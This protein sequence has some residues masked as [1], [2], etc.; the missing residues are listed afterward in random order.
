MESQACY[1]RGPL[2]FNCSSGCEILECKP[3]DLIPFFQHKW[4]AEDSFKMVG[5]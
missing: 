5:V 4:K 1:K 3:G 2:A